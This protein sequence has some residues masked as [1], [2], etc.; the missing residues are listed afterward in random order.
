MEALGVCFMAHKQWTEAAEVF[1][2][3]LE[4]NK[5]K[6]ESHVLNWAAVCSLQ[7]HRY[8]KA[9]KLYDRLSVLRRDDPRVWL[10]MGHAALGADMP[11]RARYSAEKAL[12]LDPGWNDAQVVLGCAL[13]AERKYEKSADIFEKLRDD[14][15][16]ESMAWWM[17]GRCYQQMGNEAMAQNAF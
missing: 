4:L 17:S 7:A 5:N 15:Q 13:Y 6:T 11:D 14:Q 10:E 3:L 12:Q 16:W 9:L 2:K 8:S 1:D